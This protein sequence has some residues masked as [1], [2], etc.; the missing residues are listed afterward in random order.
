MT[1]M[2]RLGVV[3]AGVLLAVTT[4]VGLRAAREV[5]TARPRR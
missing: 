5:R 2:Q 4:G 1:T 3:L